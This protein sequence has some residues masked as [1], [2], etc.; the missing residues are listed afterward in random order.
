MKYIDEYRD[1][2]LVRGLLS[3]INGLIYSLERPVTVMEI[4]GSHTY[5]VARFGLRSCLP[6]GLRLISG[7]GCP[8]CVTAAADV[9]RVLHLARQRHITIATY[10]DMLRVPGARGES[11]QSLRSRGADVQIISSAREALRIAACRP[12][13]QIVLLGIGFETTAPTVAATVK[14]GYREGIA[15]L[16][17]LSLHKTIPEALR[18]LIDDPHLRVDGFLCPGHVS[19]ITGV[20]VYEAI[21]AANRAAVVTGFEPVDILEGLLMIIQQI[22]KGRYEVA[23]QY[24]RAVRPEGNE[25]ARGVMEE[26][27]QVADAEW[28]GLGVIARSGLSLRDKYADFDALRRF[29]IPEMTVEEPRNCRCGSILR[30]VISPDD[31]P[32]FG[33][34]CTPATP[35]GPCMVSTEGS[36]AA[37]F[38]YGRRSKITA[39]E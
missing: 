10:G 16:S 26:V 33:R 24:G 5:A 35:L 7:P 14:A 23:I 28:R 20:A 3:R 29:P 34:T 13:R 15:N 4:C 22:K 9:E 25:R 21:P 18:A 36:C 8:V 2:S 30:G 11:L 31:C 17:V 12:D 1:P 27:F 19:V 39:E 37:L 38:K 6:E 32:A